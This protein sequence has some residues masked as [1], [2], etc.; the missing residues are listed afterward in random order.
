M[1]HQ[2]WEFHLILKIKS[3]TDW[4]FHQSNTGGGDTHIEAWPTHNGRGHYTRGR[5]YQA[6]LLC[7][8]EQWSDVCEGSRVSQCCCLSA[9]ACLMAAWSVHNPTVTNSIIMV[10]TDC[11]HWTLG[12]YW[13]HTGDTLGTHWRHTGDILEIYWGHT[14]DTLETHWRHTGHAHCKSF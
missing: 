6:A 2:I 14:E 3:F 9:M 13:G 7:V 5:G 1:C 12:T 4:N 11:T 10:S 8:T